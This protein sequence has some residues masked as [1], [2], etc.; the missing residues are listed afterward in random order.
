MKAPSA[1]TQL[2]LTV[3][4]LVASP[5]GPVVTYLKKKYLVYSGY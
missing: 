1:V 4:H 2:M 5:K 3:S